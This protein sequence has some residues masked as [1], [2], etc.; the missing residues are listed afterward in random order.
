MRKILMLFMLL[1]SLT[2]FAANINSSY[3][4]SLN[5]NVDGVTTTIENQ[6]V[7]VIDN[8]N[9]TVTMTIPDFQFAGFTGTVI[10][11]ASIASDGDL[12]NP[13]VSFSGLPIIRRSF[14]AKSHVNTSD[15]EIHLEMICLG[16]TIK[17]DYLGK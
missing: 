2:A 17:V 14:N 16:K 9:G 3:T 15:V 1:C 4:G 8:G 6:Q 10:I 12:T 7:T 11:D 13:K 5:V